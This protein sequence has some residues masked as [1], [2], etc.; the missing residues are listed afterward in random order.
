MLTGE[1]LVCSNFLSLILSFNVQVVK[2]HAMITLMTLRASRIEKE[3][4]R[5]FCI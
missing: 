4:K 2:S 1:N 3:K 5:L